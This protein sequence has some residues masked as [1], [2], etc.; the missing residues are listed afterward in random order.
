MHG[1]RLKKKRMPGAHQEGLLCRCDNPAH[2]ECQIYRSTRMWV[3]DHGE[4]AAA[5]FLLAWREASH[6][7]LPREH[8]KW[9][10]SKARVAA[11]IASH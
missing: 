7:E 9:R 1:V 6:E 2:G 8:K 11:Y 5:Y 10:P 3:E 4:H